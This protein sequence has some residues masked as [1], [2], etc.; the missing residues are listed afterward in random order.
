VA[1]LRVCA[2]EQPVDAAS[3]KGGALASPV[4]QGWDRG[5][6]TNAYIRSLLVTVPDWE[7]RLAQDEQ[8]FEA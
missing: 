6:D 3:K 8:V 7:E 2:P 1:S 5:P 4:L